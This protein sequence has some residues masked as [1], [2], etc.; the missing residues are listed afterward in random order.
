M[1][2]LFAET[3]WS[4]DL[5]PAQVIVLLAAL[6]WLYPAVGEMRANAG[7]RRALHNEL[8]GSRSNS[9][10]GELRQRCRKRANDHRYD[11]MA[12]VR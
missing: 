7:E 11:L 2:A 8:H 5:V 4:R 6:I 9:L 1:A 3:R 12:S 10:F